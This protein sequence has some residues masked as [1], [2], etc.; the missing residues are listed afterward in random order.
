MSCFYAYSLYLSQLS[1]DVSCSFGNTAAARGVL[2]HVRTLVLHWGYF[3]VIISRFAVCTWPGNRQ[4]HAVLRYDMGS[5]STLCMYS[6]NTQQL[7]LVVNLL[8]TRNIL[9]T[10]P[11]VYLIRH[12]S[13]SKFLSYYTEF[14]PN[15]QE[16]WLF[17]W[18]RSTIK[19]W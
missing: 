1:S 8:M 11:F 15:K 9:E 4:H 14:G 17:T 19:S 5:T 7:I 13:H 10:I 6:F 12:R 2:L 16:C 18:H 3:Y